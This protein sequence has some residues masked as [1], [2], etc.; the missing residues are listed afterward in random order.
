MKRG[1]LKR[2]YNTMGW[3]LKKTVTQN[4]QRMHKITMLNI[5]ILG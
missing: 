3:I 4:H 1:G 5:K 2:E